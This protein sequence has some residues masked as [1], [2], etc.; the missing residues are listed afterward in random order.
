MNKDEIP[1]EFINYINA[2]LAMLK[3]DD[4]DKIRLLEHIYEI[5]ESDYDL[6]KKKKDGDSQ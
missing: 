2:V 6:Y 5:T 1:N 3:L 4:D